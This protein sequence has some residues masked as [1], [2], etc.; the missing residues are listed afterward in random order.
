MVERKT[1]GY[2]R[3]AL[4]IDAMDESEWSLEKIKELIMIIQRVLYD[5]YQ[6]DLN[7][8]VCQTNDTKEIIVEDT[9]L[10]KTGLHLHW[11]KL[12]V[13]DDTTKLL[14]ESIL[15]ATATA[16]FETMGSLRNVI[17]S[18]VTKDIGLTS[19]RISQ[20]CVLQV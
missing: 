11:P 5:F 14:Y 12:V 1:I 4:D 13:D 3:F 7:C 16:G 19:Y 15:S 18:C 9:V 6:V 17:D 10:R 2:H 8:I 20:M